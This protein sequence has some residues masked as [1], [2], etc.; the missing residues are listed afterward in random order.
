MTEPQKQP[1]PKS[2]RALLIP[3]PSPPS[4]SSEE[5]AS[6]SGVIRGWGVGILEMQGQLPFGCACL[7]VH[8]S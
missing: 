8:G 2:S 7:P 5:T 6:L 4:R 3:S 1:C